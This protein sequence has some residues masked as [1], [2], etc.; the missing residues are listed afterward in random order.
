LEAE[1]KKVAKK[2]ASDEEDPA[3]LCRKPAG[4][5]MTAGEKGW[6]HDYNLKAKGIYRSGRRTSASY[7]LGTR[8]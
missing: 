1:A 3:Q 2:A 8:G 5:S 6:S 4:G 7:P